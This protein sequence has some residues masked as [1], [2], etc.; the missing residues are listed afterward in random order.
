MQILGD[1]GYHRVH[2]TQYTCTTNLCLI[3]LLDVFLICIFCVYLL[4]HYNI[5]IN[6]LSCMFIEITYY[7]D[8]MYSF[9]NVKNV[10]CQS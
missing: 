7:F 4:N 8:N 1:P 6:N 10:K 5:F 3:S 2:S 9:K